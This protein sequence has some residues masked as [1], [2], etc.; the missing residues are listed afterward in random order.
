MAAACVAAVCIAG[1]TASFFTI[2]VC[3]SRCKKR[4]NQNHELPKRRQRKKKNQIDTTSP[5]IVNYQVDNSLNMSSLAEFLQY[6][7][8]S[9]NNTESCRM[10][11]V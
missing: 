4:T 8:M 3:K 2:V 11:W 7:M 10:S 1:T 9:E 5:F 6:N